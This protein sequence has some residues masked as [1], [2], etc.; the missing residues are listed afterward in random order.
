MLFLRRGT[1][2]SEKMG[3]KIPNMKL[4]HFSNNYAGWGT[5]IEITLLADKQKEITPVVLST[6]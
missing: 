5:G 4:G 1:F 6:E 2:K 3:K